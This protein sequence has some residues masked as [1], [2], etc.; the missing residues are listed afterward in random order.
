VKLGSD[1]RFSVSGLPAGE[2]YMA[3]LVDPDPA[4]LTDPAF[5]EQLAAGA[6]RVSLAEGERKVQDVRIGG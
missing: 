4:F 3:A 1:G 6:I 5:L 2:Y